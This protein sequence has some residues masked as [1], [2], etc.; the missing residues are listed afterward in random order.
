MTQDRILV[1]IREQDAPK[2][3]SR[4]S[5]QGRNAT[6]I[7]E[8]R[9][10]DTRRLSIVLKGDLDWI[11]MKSLEKSRTRRYQ[12]AGLLADDVE[13]Y[14]RGDAVT[15]RPPSLVYLSTRLI[16]RHRVLA[17]VAAIVV[18][19]TL[20]AL[21]V[22][23][24]G[25]LKYRDGERTERTARIAVENSRQELER[26]AYFANVEQAGQRLREGNVADAKRLLGLCPENLRGW[27]HRYLSQ[28]SDESDLVIDAH[29]EGVRFS[30]LNPSGTQILSTGM[31][32]SVA[33]WDATDKS[34]IAS[35]D[36]RDATKPRIPL[37]SKQCM[38]AWIDE[39]NGRLILCLEDGEVKL[40]DSATLAEISHFKTN[41]TG[42]FKGIEVCLHGS[43]LVCLYGNELSIW[44]I[45]PESQAKPRQL[46]RI[47]VL[48]GDMK[49]QTAATLGVHP[50]GIHVAVFR[51]EMQLINLSSAEIG[52]TS[53]VNPWDGSITWESG[54]VGSSNVIFGDDGR[55]IA[56]HRDSK[57]FY[58]GS[59]KGFGSHAK[60]T[61]SIQLFKI[62][63][64]QFEPSGRFIFAGLENGQVALFE[65]EYGTERRRLN[66]H[67][68]RVTSMDVSASGELMSTSSADGTVR[69]WNIL[70]NTVQRNLHF[71]SG[72]CGSGGELWIDEKSKA[73][74]R[75]GQAGG[76]ELRDALTLELKGIIAGPET[77]SLL[78]GTALSIWKM[79]ESSKSFPPQF[80][81]LQEHLQRHHFV[82]F[83]ETGELAGIW[84]QN[85][86]SEQKPSGDEVD[87][88][89]ANIKP[90]EEMVANLAISPDDQFLAAVQADG[91][92]LVIRLLTGEVVFKET[93][94]S[95]HG[96]L[97]FIDNGRKL[98]VGGDGA[99]IL[100]VDGFRELLREQGGTTLAVSRDGRKI[101]FPIRDGIISVIDMSDD[102]TYPIL[103]V[104]LG[105]SA[106]EFSSDGETLF[107][108]GNDG[109]MRL[110]DIKSGREIGILH[111][112]GR[113]SSFGSIA[114]SSKIGCILAVDCH[115]EVY[116][117]GVVADNATGD[118][119][120]QLGTARSQSIPSVD[121]ETLLRFMSE[122]EGTLIS[123]QFSL[124]NEDPSLTSADYRVVANAILRLAQ[125]R[126]LERTP[127]SWANSELIQQILAR[128]ASFQAAGTVGE[129]R[130]VLALFATFKFSENSILASILSAATEPVVADQLISMLAEGAVDFYA[131]FSELSQAQ[132]PVLQS[133]LVTLLTE[134]KHQ[135]SESDQ[136]RLLPLLKSL[137]SSPDNSVRACTYRLIES[138][139][140]D[141]KERIERKAA[142]TPFGPSFSATG[143]PMAYFRRNLTGLS[144]PNQP[145][146]RGGSAEG[147]LPNP[148]GAPMFAVAM[149]E[150]TE[151][152]FAQFRPD[153]K[154]RSNT[155]VTNV[156]VGEMAEFCNWM[157]EREGLRPCYE[158]VR[159]S[160]TIN[161]HRIVDDSSTVHQPFEISYWTP[162]LLATGDGYRLP[163]E[164]EIGFFNVAGDTQYA[165][166]SRA[167]ASAPKS[168]ASLR[169]D[170]RGLFNLTGNAAEVR[171]R[172]NAPEVAPS[173]LP[174]EPEPAPAPPEQSHLQHPFSKP[175][176]LAQRSR[177]S[178]ESLSDP[179]EQPGSA[180]SK[181]A[182]G[183]QEMVQGTSA[184]SMDAVVWR[185]GSSNRPKAFGG[186][187]WCSPAT[188]GATVDTGLDFHE[189]RADVGFRV[190]R[191]IMPPPPGPPSFHVTEATTGSSLTSVSKPL[192]VKT[193][194]GTRVY[195]DAFAV[196]RHREL[197][198]Y[199]YE[200][201]LERPEERTRIVIND[202]GV[203]V[204]EVY[205]VMIPLTVQRLGVRTHW[206]IAWEKERRFCDFRKDV[207]VNSLPAIGSSASGADLTGR[208]Y[209][210]VESQDAESCTCIARFSSSTGSETGSGLRLTIPNDVYVPLECQSPSFRQ[211]DLPPEVAACIQETQALLD[212]DEESAAVAPAIKPTIPSDDNVP[213]LK[214]LAT[215]QGW[216]GCIS[217][218]GKSVFVSRKDAEA[219]NEGDLYRVDLATNEAV[220]ILDNTKVEACSPDGKWIA[221]SRGQGNYTTLVLFSTSDSSVKQ[222]GNGYIPSW[223][224]DSKHLYFRDMNEGS[225]MRLDIESAVLVDDLFV[226][227]F[228]EVSSDQ[229][230]QVS[231][232][233]SRFVYLD[234]D[235]DQL[236]IGR[237]SDLTVVTA[238]S[239][240]DAT[241]LLK[242]WSPSST[243]VAFAVFE[244]DGVWIMN[245]TT[246]ECRKML[247][248]SF[249]NPRFSGDGSKLSVDERSENQVHV[250]DLNGLELP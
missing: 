74:L 109:T 29:V 228:W 156:S 83:S 15:A 12:S 145:P 38:K 113:N 73:V 103:G 64:L 130:K 112:A 242:S 204:K 173:P 56:V 165:V 86:N 161:L 239:V 67:S 131:A 3:S 213:D 210:L 215:T 68:D 111:D 200:A 178:S 180:D 224:S 133:R 149:T 170:A 175:I 237:K 120:Q 13:N 30:D 250:F 104:R 10:T 141:A 192:L 50:D 5:S 81:M 84:A 220:R 176:R 55:R 201:I 136:H 36:Q 240:G 229:F 95:I 188:V 171:L 71:T 207:V 54:S 162:K 194:F 189:P 249:T 18:S 209:W 129:L 79:P 172:D 127:E 63:T 98:L 132:D 116:R 206:Q 222:L 110:W 40:V 122:L 115:N 1:A 102:K 31:D 70:G 92:C 41:G 164:S 33:L 6:T 198:E 20:M 35:S 134:L 89:T 48:C 21:L 22:S 216:S 9:S 49:Q 124:E 199:I 57:V 143:Q 100:S 61:N 119:Y 174:P 166:L 106:M 97:S 69:L 7:S 150:V 234:T 158:I 34:L 76:F 26:Q 159:E 77:F 8:Q 126:E 52:A 24:W 177:D 87:T 80:R 121:L 190:V 114:F 107:T 197:E 25:L 147:G 53:A 193:A 4:L 186:A 154:A 2:P 65:T 182:A 42:A 60:E 105:V 235:I 236:V 232:D 118:V 146:E 238:T 108:A 59:D 226:E 185:A 246:G 181:H 144:N 221:C 75:R 233:E 227:V 51:Q 208:L 223:S 183:I 138:K 99:V 135:F 72:A 153:R 46:R 247:R 203:P 202:S 91:V 39:F 14:R 157:S 125:L 225:I 93:L 16:K 219:T 248:G 179:P 11:T 163:S 37:G 187:F 168:V 44:D 160:E 17:S 231:P 43:G 244:N 117:W 94:G 27:E 58:S 152:Q 128:E 167:V 241:M 148:P 45:S 88:E 62:T 184:S 28:V 101:A 195:F 211:Q 214:L 212:R 23:I 123:G 169:P 66:G 82:R 191:D 230:A 142:M 78:Q 151:E 205:T 85:V 245:A 218:D 32:G 137:L 139:L 155:P 90:V 19:S 47:P 96:R 217:A 243:H 196:R 140:P